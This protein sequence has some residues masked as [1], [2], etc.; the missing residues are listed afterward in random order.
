MMAVTKVWV[1]RPN[2][3][4]TRIQIPSSVST[5]NA[6]LPSSVAH[7]TSQPIDLD[8]TEDFLVD[9]LREVILKRYPQSLGKHHDTADLTIRIHDNSE[10]DKGR[11]LAP[12][13]SVVKILMEEYPNGQKSSEAWTIITSGGRDIYTRWWLQT[14]GFSNDMYPVRGTFSPNQLVQSAGGSYGS[15]AIYS[16]QQEY[17]PYTPQ[18]AAL[19][20]PGEV[21]TRPRGSGVIMPI[22]QHSR[23]QPRPPLRPNR[24]TLQEG[25]GIFPGRRYDNTNTS[26]MVA[27]AASGA[28]SELSRALRSSPDSAGSSQGQRYPPGRNTPPGEYTNRAR[29]Y[30]KSTSAQ[31]Q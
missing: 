19:T 2:S 20:P 30:S 5:P 11:V 23:T 8:I 1:R 12:D 29:G 4:P 3:S 16:Q 21:N 6:S 24:S 17:F 13:E 27:E 31:G 14:G 22:N 25:I 15:E 10:P 26:S 18:Q 9:D 28:E 7:D